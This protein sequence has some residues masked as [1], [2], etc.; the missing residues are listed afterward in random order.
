MIGLWTAGLA[1]RRTRRLPTALAGIALAV[2]LVAALGGFLT[3]SKETRTRRAVRSL[4]VDWQAQV[5]PGAVMSLVRKA[6]GTRAALSIGFA[7]TTGVLLGPA[8][9]ADRLQPARRPGATPNRSGPG[10]HRPAP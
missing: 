1:R 10:R 3:A 9:T 6:P 8:G 5:Q 4:A 2:T 7:H